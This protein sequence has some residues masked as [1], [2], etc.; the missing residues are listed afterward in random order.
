MENAVP[1]LEN[2]PPKEETKVLAEAP[3]RVV[4]DEEKPGMKI[5]TGP[6]VNTANKQYEE[7]VNKMI[8]TNPDD[9]E[10]V[11]FKTAKLRELKKTLGYEEGESTEVSLNDKF[12]EGRKNA[13]SSIRDR[14]HEEKLINI[15]LE[16]KRRSVSNKPFPAPKNFATS[17]PES[18]KIEAI[19]VASTPIEKPQ[20]KPAFAPI[21][22]PKPQKYLHLDQLGKGEVPVEKKEE[23]IE[24]KNKRIAEANARGTE[25]S[26]AELAYYTE[27]KHEIN[28]LTIEFMRSP[29]YTGKAVQE[30]A[31]EKIM[32]PENELA[33]TNWPKK[34]SGAWK[35][36]GLVAFNLGKL[37]INETQLKEQIPG[38]FKLTPAQQNYCL[39]KLR[40]KVGHDLDENTKIELAETKGPKRLL[41]AFRA[42][43]VRSRLAKE[44]K[45]AGLTS[46]KES[47]QTI[48]E[49][50]SNRGLDV[51]M[52]EK[53]MALK[54]WSHEP[55]NETHRKMIEEFNRTATMLAEIPYDR[56]TDDRTPLQIL[57]KKKYEKAR[58][59]FNDAEA[60][61]KLYEIEKVP[62]EI[63]A[64][65][66]EFSNIEDDIR[67]NQALTY[68]P[69]V[70]SWVGK[71]IQK[72]GLA[73][74][75]VVMAAGFA[76]RGLAKYAAGFGGGL[77]ASAFLGGAM[78]KIRKG[79]EFQNINKDKRY[80]DIAQ[81]DE[82]GEAKLEKRAGVKE[83]IDSENYARKITDL[84]KRIEKASPEKREALVQTLQNRVMVARERDE[85]GLVR[86]GKAKEESRNKLAL[87]T[88]MK[89]AQAI[90]MQNDPEFM[91]RSLEVAERLND[92]YFKDEEKDIAKK[93][94]M[95][96]AF[97]R[98]ARNGAIFFGLGFEANDWL[99]H[100]GEATKKGLEWLNNTTKEILPIAEIAEEMRL[101]AMQDLATVS[102][103]NIVST[104]MS[105]K[106]QVAA[107]VS[108]IHLDQVTPE[109]R[110]AGAIQNELN[111]AEFYSGHADT[112]RI[113]PV[114]VE[115][116]PSVSVIKQNF[117]Q[118]VGG[119]G[120]IGA[121]E[122]LQHKLTDQYGDKIPENL[123][124]FVAARPEK[125]AQEWGFYRPG[126][127]N[128]SA[129]ILK[130]AKFGVADNGEITFKD[131]TGRAVRLD[132][133]ASKFDG[134][135][136]D[137][138]HTEAV[139]NKPAEPVFERYKFADSGPKEPVLPH[140]ETETGSSQ[141]IEHR[142]GPNTY[143]V[144]NHDPSPGYEST[145]KSYE[146]HPENSGHSAPWWETSGD[147]DVTTPD[148]PEVTTSANAEEY[149]KEVVRTT[150]K[151]VPVDSKIIKAA[152]E[153][154][155]EG[156]V[157]GNVVFFKNGNIG[158]Y[159]ESI[160]QRVA[161]SVATSSATANAHLFMG[162]EPIKSGT[163]VG[164]GRNFVEQMATKMPDGTIRVLAIYK[165]I[166]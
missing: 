53:G 13:E 102:D 1:K 7:V 110:V 113:N 130:G 81:P 47:L 58:A 129:S 151:L 103:Q 3:L 89:E 68:N 161:Q 159:S 158:F 10:D 35:P 153:K 70:T 162:G 42:G 101:R 65:I 98:G 114:S 25:L 38:F 87:F 147:T 27:H 29:A 112:V 123:K 77:V 45:A 146:I 48:T 90:I 78:G 128:E 71:Q 126:E 67:M 57:Q 26:K 166:E 56:T 12:N 61:L 31:A 4:R 86:F 79:Q 164:M 99:M 120:A 2:L 19:P 119:R 51:E 140:Y 34:E 136:Y 141:T 118:A 84:I 145:V 54:F 111:R 73:E 83:F 93:A 116:A 50:M 97:W 115:S 40:Q 60:R 131:N 156:K 142:P 85:M 160:D 135:F 32:P 75:G 23:S 18:K 134:K 138:G 33:K 46:Y 133:G 157:D 76:T 109:L 24:A 95:K 6:Y 59:L 137:G 148:S 39:E 55:K 149:S 88:S 49:F 74:K 100:G 139:S 17:K 16:G 20:P 5:S 154:Y 104:I 52:T 127:V 92:R 41:N 107:G 8:T 94:E 105:A 37:G 106:E 64:K 96:K 21:E 152:V 82:K 43:G 62:G 163:V 28:P 22:V 72:Y 132:G 125:L 117:E 108:N 63:N 36:D 121:I 143:M 44:T 15:A 69:E 155:G 91:A 9:P 66:L 80:G 144:E 150:N 14:K 165:K 122:D 124:S 30:V 11:D